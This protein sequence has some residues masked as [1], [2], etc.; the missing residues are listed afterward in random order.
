MLFLHVVRITSFFT[1]MDISS[2]RGNVLECLIIVITESLMV[3]I[4]LANEIQRLS[5][6]SDIGG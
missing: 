1:H 6:S 3:A 5:S 2:K 4:D